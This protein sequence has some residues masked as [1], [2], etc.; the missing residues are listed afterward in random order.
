VTD[1]VSAARN[2][3]RTFDHAKQAVAPR[4][5]D[6]YP[7]DSLASV[8]Y[9][10]KLLPPAL[11]DS[12]RSLPML[13]AGCGDG[14]MS[15]FF[16]SLGFSVTAVDHE[17]TAHNQMQGVRA[18]KTAL[19][20]SIDIQS[21]DL[22]GRFQIRGGPFGIS[23]LLGV[24]YHLKNPFYALEYLAQKSRFCILS[25]R[26]ARRTPRGAAMQD[27]ALAYLVDAQELNRDLTNYWILS[28]AAL[29]RM[30]TR[31]GW[32]VKSFETSGVKDS[33]PVSSDERAWCLLESRVRPERNVRLGEGWYDLE[34][35]TYRWTEA[36]FSIF[37][38]N[39]TS[40]SVRFR[41]T[42]LHALT[43]SCAGLPSMDYPVPGEH[44]YSGA[45]PPD[46]TGELKFTIDPPLQ[47]PA[48]PRT[49][50]VL[51][52]FWREGIETSDDN[53]PLDVIS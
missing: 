5:F 36:S 48:D 33:D 40:G 8:P 26:I 7:Y 50:G 39:V 44:I 31:A 42:S 10:A 41:F 19:A 2:F 1:L 38:L 52:S 15:F 53:L 27:E 28:P 22:D 32:N 30:A 24:L 9:I 13:D 21:A 23:L 51:V 35:G 43:L 47:P 4:S 18:L 12:M 3:Q 25:T 37:L 20:S 16:E 46:F 45:L 11:L 49:L 29:Q 14:V 34:A 17:L 6:W